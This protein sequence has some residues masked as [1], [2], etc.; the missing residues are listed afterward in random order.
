MGDMC[1]LPSQE[2][3]NGAKPR[4]VSNP[5][6]SSEIRVDHVLKAQNQVGG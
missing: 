2:K 4:N 3:Q 6:T 1:Q 5:I